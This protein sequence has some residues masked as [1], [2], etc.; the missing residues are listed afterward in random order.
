[1][2]NSELWRPSEA[3]AAKTQLATFMKYAG[4]GFEDEA[5]DYDRL[6]D[7]SISDPADFWQKIW[8]FCE[9]IGDHGDC[10]IEEGKSIKDTRFFPTARLNFAENL[11][12]RQGPDLAIIFHGENGTRQSLSW[13]DLHAQVS[14]LQQALIREGVGK[15]DR[16]AGFLPNIP[17]AVIAMLATTSLGAIWSSCS[18]DFGAAGVLDRFEQIGPKVLFCA[19]GY[20][21][22]GKCFSSLNTAQKLL[23]NMPSVRRIVVFPYIDKA[24]DIELAGKKA[25]LFNDYLE[26]FEAQPITYVPVG[27]NDPVYI[28]FSSGTTG[29]P[30]CILHSVGGALLQHLKEH[31]LHNDIRPGDR[32]FY[33]TTCGWMMWN[34]QASALASEATLVLYDGS[35]FYSDGYRM[36]DIVEAEK[37]THFGTSSKYLEASSNINIS[38]GENRNFSS[39]RTLLVT[40]SPL[41]PEYFD[42]VYEHWKS[43][44]C[45][46][47]MAGGTDVLC[48][49]VGS[50]PVSPVYRG[51]CPKRM[52][53]MNV[54][55]FDES[56]H[57]VEGVT[58][59][60]VCLSAHPSMPI[61]FLGD[62]YG[63]RYHAAYFDRYD[64]IWCQGDWVLLTPELGL[65]FQGR[66]DATL[67]PGG[68]RIG[69]AE[70]YRQVERLS[71]IEEALVVGQSWEN[72]TRVILFVKLRDGISLTDAL[73]TVI[74][75]EIRTNASPRHVP[76]KILAIADIPRTKSGKITELAAR[77]V[78]EGREVKNLHALANPYAL[79]LFDGLPELQE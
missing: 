2:T 16:V 57:S 23:A 35:P 4:V 21:Y 1:M 73:V 44:L 31:K 62:T 64:N 54:R 47:V 3:R 39:L 60:L 55:V 30:K 43:D 5:P 72:D 36:S 65:I 34:W 45:L 29:L 37:V 27:F 15:G 56:G 74:R 48:C 22:G 11:L 28:L 38:P 13:D 68:I 51:Q 42:Y 41:A 66:S 71:E 20:E 69:T 14:L 8:G 10:V 50:S 58:G 59:E 52:L 78:I 63:S 17:G 9:V 33:F 67:N 24:P 79:S 61:G 6:W 40:G 76:A 25:V 46:N 7:Y 53:G 77:D 18:P 75:N 49:F 70:I 32:L 12:R 26:E 19:D